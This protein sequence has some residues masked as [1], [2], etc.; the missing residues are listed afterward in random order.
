M[1]SLSTAKPGENKDKKKGRFIPKTSF[2]P[3]GEVLETPLYMGV[4]MNFQKVKLDRFSPINRLYPQF[5]ASYPQLFVKKNQRH[6][7]KDTH[8]WAVDT[9]YTGGLGLLKKANL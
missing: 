9:G 8:I 1:R 7:R 4:Q 3:V 2:T 5:F 6:M